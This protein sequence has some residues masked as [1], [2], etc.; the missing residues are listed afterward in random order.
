M[1]RAEMENAAGP[2]LMLDR[3][4]EHAVRRMPHEFSSHDFIEMLES[5]YAASYAHDLALCTVRRGFPQSLAVLNKA[6]TDKLR[7]LDNVKVIGEK[8][9]RNIRGNKHKTLVWRRLDSRRARTKLHDPVLRIGAGARQAP[10]G[11]RPMTGAQLREARVARGWTQTE[12]ARR[13]GLSLASMTR[14]ENG[15]RNMSWESFEAIREALEKGR[16]AG[17]K[18]AAR[19]VRQRFSRGPG[20]PGRPLPN[21]EQL[22]QARLALGWTQEELARASGVALANISRWER[23]GRPMKA[24]NFDRIGPWLASGLNRIESSAERS[25]PRT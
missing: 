6:I 21:G 8:E 11:G 4:I 2:L 20:T 19:R 18:E 5:A 14:W 3:W 9:S 22:R 1:S 17:R 23:D 24:K 16:S 15:Q 25:P 13:S 12:L 10:E 7:T